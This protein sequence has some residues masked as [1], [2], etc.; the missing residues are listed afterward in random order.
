MLPP[1]ALPAPHAT[2]ARILGQKTGR[3][4]GVAQAF[5]PSPTAFAKATAVMRLRRA[6]RSSRGTGVRAKEG[7]PAWRG[8]A[9]PT[10]VRYNE[11]C[12]LAAVLRL[13]RFLRSRASRRPKRG[14]QFCTDSKQGVRHELLTQRPCPR[15]RAANP[16]G[17]PTHD[18]NGRTAGISWRGARIGGGVDAPLQRGQRQLRRPH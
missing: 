7:R 1:R 15:P 6:R 14:T 13:P 11:I 18:G 10:A 3:V 9:S 4:A 5:P 2:G 16:G 8:G 12:D 17:T